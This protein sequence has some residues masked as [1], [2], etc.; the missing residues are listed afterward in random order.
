MSTVEKESYE[1]EEVQY[2]EDLSKTTT[3]G[4]RN[5]DIA[6]KGTGHDGSIRSFEGTEEERAYVRK[7]N[8]YIYP[9]VGGIIFVQV[10]ENTFVYD[11]ENE[12]K[13]ERKKNIL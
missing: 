6:E 5:D 8:F 2:T 4:I 12:R 9:L 1:K 13:K 3:T 11:K 10:Y 7:L